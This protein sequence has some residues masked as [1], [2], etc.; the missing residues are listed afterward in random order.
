MP[1]DRLNVV[2]PAALPREQRKLDREPGLGLDKKVIRSLAANAFTLAE[3]FLEEMD[4]HFRM[5]LPPGN[6]NSSERK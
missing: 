2:Q 1:T 6:N 5:P 4:K 3:A